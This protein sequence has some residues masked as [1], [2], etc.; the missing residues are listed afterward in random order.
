M[1][2]SN[3]S[4]KLSFLVLLIFLFSSLYAS[5]TRVATMGGGGIFVKDQ[6]LVFLFPGTIHQYPDL[7]VAEMRAR[8]NDAFYSLGM[9]MDYGN[10]VSGLYINQPINSLALAPLGGGYFAQAAELNNALAYMLGL[11]LGGFDAGFGFIGASSTYEDNTTDPVIK[12]KAYYAGIVAGISNDDMD[13]GLKFEL[14]SVEIQPADSKYSGFV[15]MAN[16]RYRLMER[17]GFHIFPVASFGFGTTE[18]KDVVEFGLLSFALGIGVEKQ[19]NEDNLLVVGLEVSRLSITTTPDGGDETVDAVSTLPGIYV[20]V[21]SRIS[22]WLIG[23]IGATQVNQLISE[24]FDGDDES[25]TLS[26][27]RLSLGLGMEFSNFLIDFNMN[28]TSL[29]DGIY[30]FDGIGGTTF[31]STV[32]ITYNFGGGDDE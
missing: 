15:L 30:I 6:S 12:E 4:L 28:E 32:S 3:T 17:K 16:G 26:E 8:N 2:I 10:M 31:A 22:S 7:V 24:E 1:R 23:R 5:E 19:I 11:K 20:G 29:F 14:P 21:E 13:I 27:F 9:H 25:I 18:I